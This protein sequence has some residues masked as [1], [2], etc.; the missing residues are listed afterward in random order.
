MIRAYDDNGNV[1]DLIK[2]RKQIK[3]A[4]IDEFVFMLNYIINDI[5]YINDGKLS[6]DDIK[7]ISTLLKGE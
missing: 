5:P 3:N 2:M 7:A 1:V 6:I 4:A